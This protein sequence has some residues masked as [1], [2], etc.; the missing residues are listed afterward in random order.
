MF[1]L[2]K[3]QPKVKVAVTSRDARCSVTRSRASK[4]QVKQ[5]ET[6]I[7]QAMKKGCVTPSAIAAETSIS[8]PTV[9][10]RLKNMVAKKMIRMDYAG[11]MT[12]YYPASARKRR[13]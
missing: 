13:K 10:V 12:S 4:K 3:R 2:F 1:K 5:Q 7:L 9:R 8:L 6:L 11:P